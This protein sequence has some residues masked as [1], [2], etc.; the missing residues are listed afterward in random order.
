MSRSIPIVLLG[1]MLSLEIDY[2]AGAKNILETL[3]GSNCAIHS[4]AIIGAD[5]FGF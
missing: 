3:I 5:G 1:I 4:G 2:F